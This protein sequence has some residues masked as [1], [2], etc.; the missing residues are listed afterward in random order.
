MDKI[1]NVLMVILICSFTILTSYSWGR[2]V[3]LGCTGLILC[4]QV[5]R[6]NGKYKLFSGVFPFVLALFTFYSLIS[7]LW[8]E[9]S[10]DSI[11]V[12]K[13]LF[14]ITVMVYIL[15]TCYFE[16]PKNTNDLL[17]CIKWSGYIISLYSIFFYGLDFL[18]IAAANETRL[19]NTYANVNTIGMLS[20]ICIVIQVDEFICE[21]RWKWEALLCLPS[22]FIV[23]L[24]HSRKALLLL[25]LGTFLCFLLHNLDSKNILKT[26]G[27]ISAI[28]LGALVLLN[29]VA[30]MPIFAGT[31][32]RM[33]A[34][35]GSIFG[36]GGGADSSVLIR[37]RMIEVGWEQFLKTPLLGMGMANPHILSNMYLGKDAYLHNNFIEL[38]A[39]GGIV[40]LSI[41]Y[42]MYA[43][44]LTMF[45]KLRRY[46]NEEYVI[47]LVMTVVLLILDYGMVSYYQ[48]IRYVYLLVMFLEIEALKKKQNKDN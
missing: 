1:I 26:I 16:N 14:E 13:T 10:T 19:E 28:V 12:G 18:I 2:Y 39:G 9:R 48:K 25:I 3:M 31:F 42:S 27:K 47:C 8:A 32:D 5:F 41:Y 29:V 6:N 11:T 22:I 24:T 23:A 7:S 36:D 34:L 17:R 38:L 4:V 46:K 45:W 30:L 33:N 35:F 40:G 37:D 20:S 21:K 15:Y 43:Y 44:L